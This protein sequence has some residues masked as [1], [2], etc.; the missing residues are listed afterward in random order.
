MKLY[1]RFPF[2]INVA[3]DQNDSNTLYLSGYEP[4]LKKT[5]FNI[6]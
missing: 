5:I 1:Q 2:N 4:K 6:I 3:K